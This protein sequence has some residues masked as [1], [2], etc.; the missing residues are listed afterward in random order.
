MP[1]KVFSDGDVLTAAEVMTFM[2]EQQIAVFDDATA[3]NAAIVNP[4][5][6]M[7][8]YIKTPGRFTYYNGTSWR[9]V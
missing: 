4:V 9:S 3:R 1:Y 7:I 2:M 6:G 5:H 8:A